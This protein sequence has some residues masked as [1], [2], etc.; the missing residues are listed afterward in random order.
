MSFPCLKRPSGFPYIQNKIPG[1]GSLSLALF[2]L[3]SSLPT[4]SQSHCPLHTK[5]ICLRVGTRHSNS[6]G[7]LLPVISSRVTPCNLATFSE[8][9]LLGS[10]HVTLPR[11]SILILFIALFVFSFSPYCH[12]NSIHSC[13]SLCVEHPINICKSE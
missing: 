2:H 5:L 11:K 10:H 8:Q 1:M 4:M 9:P 7:T 13:S 12:G 6:P 3:L